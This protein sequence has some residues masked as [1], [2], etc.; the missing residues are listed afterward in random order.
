MVDAMT[1]LFDVTDAIH[2]YYAETQ[3]YICGQVTISESIKQKQ[4][5]MILKTQL[6]MCA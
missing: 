3:L 2:H 5:W 1:N 4:L 6:Q